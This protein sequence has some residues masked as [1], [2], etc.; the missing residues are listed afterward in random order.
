MPYLFI[1]LVVKY[2]AQL[3]GVNQAT[4]Q[5]KLVRWEPAVNEKKHSGKEHIESRNLQN[6]KPWKIQKYHQSMSTI[7]PSFLFADRPQARPSINC[8]QLIVCSILVP[9]DGDFA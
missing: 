4:L 9:S 8:L 7:F 2:V 3:L 1:I 6:D 5:E